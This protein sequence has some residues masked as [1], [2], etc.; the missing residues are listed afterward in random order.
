M[1]KTKGLYQEEYSVGSFVRIVKHENLEKFREEWQY[2][3]K[4]QPEQ[5]EYAGRTAQVQEAMFYHGGDEIYTLKD[6]PGI[7]HE[8]CLE[9]YLEKKE[10]T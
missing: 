6:V 1:G 8:Q 9:A 5:M 2:H 10:D 3:N 7:W 4:L